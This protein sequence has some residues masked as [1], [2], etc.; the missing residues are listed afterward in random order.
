MNHRLP[1]IRPFRNIIFDL[2]G[3]LIDSV[4]MTCAIIDAMMADRGLTVTADRALAR[5]MDAL[6]GTAMIAA[7]LGSHCGD[8]QR[9]IAEF[10]A[11]HAVVATPGDL[12]FPGVPETLRDL[13]SAGIG[14]AI[15]SNKP[16]GLCE[17]IL[18]DLGL[19]RH[20]VAI[21]GSRCDL[22]K[23]PAP[24]AARL[25]LAAL[26][27]DVENTLYIGDSTVDVATAAAVGLPVALVPWGY[28]VSDARQK[29]ATLTV[30]KTFAQLL[31][32]AALP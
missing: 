25:A 28:G 23:K 21:I 24:D 5:S 11:R 16:Q 17:K 12:A 27:A 13:A 31:D 18:A 3:T 9:E 6:G 19:S 1:G 29:N 7:V 8:P 10:R 22:P 14:M 32:H 4:R 30:L 26:G 2:D 20:F 15:C